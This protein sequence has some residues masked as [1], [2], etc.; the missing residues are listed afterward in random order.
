MGQKIQESMGIWCAVEIVVK[1]RETKFK[2][3]GD[4]KKAMVIPAK[5]NVNEGYG[6]SRFQPRST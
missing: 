4:S 2:V 6:Y 3:R 5:V 1:E